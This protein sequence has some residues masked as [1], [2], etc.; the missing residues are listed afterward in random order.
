MYHR[1]LVPLLVIDCWYVLMNDCFAQEFI[2]VIKEMLTYFELK[3]P[4]CIFGIIL[5]L[6][7]FDGV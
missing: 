7:I 4:V 5:S 2:F 1:T 3:Y 6:K